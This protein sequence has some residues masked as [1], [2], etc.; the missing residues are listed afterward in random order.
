MRTDCQLITLVVQL[1]KS[2]RYW[3]DGYCPKKGAERASQENFQPSGF[4]VAEFQRGS[5]V[6]SLKSL[7]E[8]NALMARHL[9]DRMP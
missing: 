2:F 4:S 8:N 7:A 1:Q 5:G 3:Q 6:E 9:E